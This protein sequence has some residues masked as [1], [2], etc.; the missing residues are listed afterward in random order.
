LRGW[1]SPSTPKDEH[2]GWDSPILELGELGRGGNEGIF[3][4]NNFE[5][6]NTPLG[7]GK[8]IQGM[9]KKK[10]TL[11]ILALTKKVKSNSFE[12]SVT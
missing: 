9:S 11:L 3:Q 7:V 12:I 10:G 5:F 6:K 8:I 4:I 1:E 2:S